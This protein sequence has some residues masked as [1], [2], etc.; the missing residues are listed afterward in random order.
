MR[1]LQT[2]RVEHLTK[3]YGEK[4]L[5]ED[6][7]FIIN[8]HD[9]IGLIGTN[10]SGKTT[11]LNAISGLDPADSGELIHANDYEIGYLQQNPDLA[12]DKTVLEAV[13]QGSA[14]VFKI[15]RAYEQ[16]LQKLELNPT[17]QSAIEQYTKAEERMNE[18]DAWNAESDVKTILTQLHLTELDQKVAALSGGQRKRVG[19]AQVL[20]QSPDLLIL[21]EPTNHLDFDSI[22]WLEE[23]L[24]NYQGALLIVT[25]DRYF[26]DHVAN[27]IYEL[28]FGKMSAYQGNYEDFVRQ[29]AERQEQA[30]QQEHKNQQLY[31]KELAWMK[32]GAKARSTKQQA[33]INRFEK[34]ADQVSDKVQVDQNID[35]NLGQQRLGKK[36]L[37]LK[38]A[39]LKL[40]DHQIITDFSTM[41]NAGDRIGITGKN[42]AGKSS[43]LNVLAGQTPLDQGEVII[44]E[45][46]RTAYYRQQTEPIPEDKR[47]IN[48]LNEVAQ[49]V[50]N[51]NGERISTTQL[52]EQ[53]LFPKFMHGTLI[54]KLS[55]GEKR[56]LYLLKLLM[57]QP[58]VLFLDEPTNDLD[59]GTL[60]ILENYLETFAGTVIT[61]SHDRYFLD[62]VA[63][64]LL[65]FNGDAKIDR[66]SGQFT[67]YL[68]LEQQ[69]QPAK[70][71][72][73]APTPQPTEP[74]EPKVK[75]K[76]TYAEQIE[77][78][79]LEKEIDQIDQ[80]MTE[81][82][83]QMSQTNGN[84]YLQLG[85]LQ[86][87]LNDLTQKSEE[88][89]ARWEE[90]G[91]Y[92]E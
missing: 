56:R 89:M 78:D 39:S 76:L 9:R 31:K 50:I 68:Q 36:V 27:Q 43:F 57:M 91:Q 19:L 8:E 53:F 20:I 16:A 32:T 46:V 58:N 75:T 21:D 69:Q 2:L 82:N 71:V 3:T 47:V 26:L 18:E 5:F 34:L 14:P 11:L 29:K 40:G 84:D 33:R 60:T 15:I 65:I 6:L 87:Q 13:F 42:G 10:G 41:I 44:G 86:Q 23:Y 7:N 62:K 37:Q 92:V 12:T 63:D 59:V 73:S 51:S 66:Y 67:D 64:Q 24:K 4:T 88:K 28:S 83:E 45:T 54:R 25:H 80:Q 49:N 48:Y 90:L 22:D 30:L 85:D 61:V 17:D 74:A 77:F 35:I 52:L 38:N 72:A 55:G 79:K 70:K 81:V 1:I